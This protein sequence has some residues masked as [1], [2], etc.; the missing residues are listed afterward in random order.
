MQQPIFSTA[1]FHHS[2]ILAP[3]RP[4]YIMPER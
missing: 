2:L 3:T 1:I 4:L